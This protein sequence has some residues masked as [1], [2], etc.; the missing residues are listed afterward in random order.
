M[1]T[2]LMYITCHMITNPHG[3]VVGR[4]ASMCIYWHPNDVLLNII[5]LTVNFSKYSWTYFKII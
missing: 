1:L 2:L 5:G 4:F 3:K